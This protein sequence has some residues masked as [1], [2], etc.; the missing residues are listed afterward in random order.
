M[1]G[2]QLLIGV[3]F[4]SIVAVERFFFQASPSA[5]RRAEQPQEKGKRCKAPE[6]ESQRRGD[7]G[8]FRSGNEDDDVEPGD[9]D[10]VHALILA[11]HGDRGG[12]CN[13]TNER[14][15]AAART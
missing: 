9:R 1:K 11:C 12:A 13:N 15:A 5:R 8:V 4:G 6:H 14:A 2:P 10:Q 7:E 3:R